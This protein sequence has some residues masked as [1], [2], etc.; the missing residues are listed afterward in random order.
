M[1]HQ[2]VELKAPGVEM[3]LE[4]DLAEKPALLLESDEVT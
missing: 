2:K 3:E 4:D 1:P